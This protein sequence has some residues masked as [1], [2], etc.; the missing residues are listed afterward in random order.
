MVDNLP[1]CFR[2]VNFEYD[3]TTNPWDHVCRFENT[4]YSYC[5]KCRVIA[6]ILTKSAQTWFSQLGDGSI[7]DFEQLTTLFLHQFASL[8]K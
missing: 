8:R 3:G 1:A 4:A 2:L 7:H 5:G 6:T